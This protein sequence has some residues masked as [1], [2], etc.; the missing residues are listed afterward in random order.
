MADVNL[1]ASNTL[2]GPYW[3]AAAVTPADGADLAKAPCDA[4]YI[5]TVGDV[6]VVTA[7]GDTVTFVAVPVGTVLRIR[8]D[9][10]RAT[11]TTT[12]AGR[13]GILALYTS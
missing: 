6:S 10:V 3:R 7:A 13:A 11:G 2:E 4:L 1:N 8:A 9:R 12:G 5:G